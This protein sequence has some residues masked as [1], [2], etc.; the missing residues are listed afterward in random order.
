MVALL[1]A[2]DPEDWAIYTLAPSRHSRALTIET[3]RS[4]IRLAGV[5]GIS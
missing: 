4:L 2:K 1:V 3:S 5:C